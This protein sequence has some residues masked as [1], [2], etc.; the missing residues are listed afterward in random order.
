M[1]R[2]ASERAYCLKVTDQG[3]HQDSWLKDSWVGPAS[4]G[5]RP[6]FVRSHAYE[7]LVREL[8]RYQNN[9]VRGRSFLISGHRGS[10]KTSL[11][12][13]AV[14]ELRENAEGDHAAWQRPLLVKLHGPSLLA[15][16]KSQEAAS[17][18]AQDAAANANPSAETE[19]ARSSNHA[20]ESLL[21]HITNALY[22]AFA[23]EIAR[24]YG[25]LAK[26]RGPIGGD[27]EIAELTAQ[28][29]LSLDET[30]EPATL[31]EYW[32]R[33]GALN[34]GVLW[35]WRPGGTTG[36]QFGTRDRPRTAPAKG[37][38]ARIGAL[39]DQ[40]Q[41]F[42]Q[43]PAEYSLDDGQG[44]REIVALATAAQ[45]YRV[46]SGAVSYGTE[47]KDVQEDDKQ[48]HLQTKPNLL[49]GINSL[50]GLLAGGTAGGLTLAAQ[51]GGLSANG[52]ML[53]A[54]IG[55]ATVL[56]TSLALNWTSTRKR[57]Q[58][59]TADYTFIRDTGVATLS[60]E[61]PTITER[62]R[63]TG[64]AP[65]FVVDELDKLDLNDLDEGMDKLVRQLKHLV[66][67]Y[68][69]FCFLTDRDYF[70]HLQYKTR[71]E[72]YPRE[73]TYFSHRLFVLYRPKELHDYLEKILQPEYSAESG[74]MTDTEDLE[75]ATITGGLRPS[76]RQAGSISGV[77]PR[78]HKRMIS[79]LLMHRAMMHVFDLQREL[80]R[81]CDA[82]DHI[83]LSNSELRTYY[84]HHIMIQL[85]VEHLL[86]ERNQRHR[87]TEDPRFGQVIY[88]VLNF[89]TRKWIEGA[90]KLDASER[91][92]ADYLF[93]RL[94]I[95]QRLQP[96][97]SGS[98]DNSPPL[99]PTD[100]TEIADA[101]KSTDPLAAVVDESDRRELIAL[102][103]GLL[104][105]LSDPTELKAKLSTS[106]DFSGD[107]E[108]WIEDLLQ[109]I[110]PLLEE[111]TDDTGGDAK[112]YEWRQDPFGRATDVRLDRGQQEQDEDDVRLID[113]L[114]E[115]LTGDHDFAS[116]LEAAKV[117][118]GS[119]AWTEVS[120][121]R[122]RLREWRK[123]NKKYADL[124]SDQ[125]YLSQ[126]ARNLKQR[127]NALVLALLLGASAG[128]AANKI[129]RPN[130][131]DD[132]D[133]PWTKQ[134]RVIAG[135]NAVTRIL[136]L[137]SA[138]PELAMG[139]LENFVK[140]QQ[141]TSDQVG[142]ILEGVR[143]SSDRVI[144]AVKNDFVNIQ[145]HV[146][147]AVDD[148]FSIPEA[149]LED[150]VSYM[151]RSW[152]RWKERTVEA[153]KGGHRAARPTFDEVVLEAAFWRIPPLDPVSQL[154]IGQWSDL[155]WSAIETPSFNALEGPPL[156]VLVPAVHF[157]GFHDEF[158][159]L[160]EVW[161]K[162]AKANLKDGVPKDELSEARLKSWPEIAASQQARHEKP[163]S[164]RD[165]ALFLR[166]SSTLPGLGARYDEL[167]TPTADYGALTVSPNRLKSKLR[168]PSLQEWRTQFLERAGFRVLFVD[169]RA[170]RPMRDEDRKSLPEAIAD[171]P[172]FRLIDRASPEDL[173]NPQVIVKPKSLDDAMRR[174]LFAPA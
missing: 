97:S 107:W 76:S 9:E 1:V 44:H 19:Q 39:R 170:D 81:L 169:E 61:L 42:W 71:R 174:A 67:D 159:Q 155:L 86:E 128:Q 158:D 122:E 156:W 160:D 150:G 146:G 55:V 157:L 78:V 144:E 168:T 63:V 111:V 103:D 11:V 117:L 104:Q 138:G 68:S 4:S 99:K 33:V 134:D 93:E 121:G 31:R 102:L 49:E 66:A 149:K 133:E 87:L 113:G 32:R 51:P 18:E 79:L 72:P 94:S 2:V 70:E 53:A 98:T 126:Y 23:G 21:K 148:I 50:L 24:C 28:L 7:L 82:N 35:H 120:A 109:N 77:P 80:A 74:R 5:G 166:L 88:D 131:W 151:N 145:E 40:F 47:K 142:A 129:K 89:P 136:R 95:E 130:E 65:V 116:D 26:R 43:F 59:V 172:V 108:D 114:L 85:A 101:G 25:Q 119:P 127:V 22:R 164:Q 69:F 73:H 8:R 161:D 17:N 123:T 163:P 112:H 60:R 139:L 3:I 45:A 143:K 10:G 41:R 167:W 75:S 171:L 36:G 83:I 12:L 115:D 96:R 14:E 91:A 173:R 118:I 57:T 16:D 147:P 135:V 62:I 90:A 46:V 15:L 141:S 106:P 54:V 29:Q 56:G 100:E 38:R 13:R 165:R 132:D 84:R 27:S 140:N 34:R 30:P 110:S 37:I 154:S 125:D 153:V 58:T 162:I 124:H 137:G 105:L 64:L 52:V 152:R 20:T 48:L 6:Q 92:L